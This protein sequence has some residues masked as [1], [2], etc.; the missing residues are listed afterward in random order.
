MRRWLHLSRLTVIWRSVYTCQ[1]QKV[2]GSTFMIPSRCQFPD[3]LSATL[4]P[5]FPQPNLCFLLQVQLQ[6]EPVEA[7]K[8]LSYCSHVWFLGSPA[9]NHNSTG[10]WVGKHMP[11]F[12]VIVSFAII[13]FRCSGIKCHFPMLCIS[14]RIRGN[15]DGT[16]SVPR[17]K[18]CQ[19]P[20][21]RGTSRHFQNA[22]PSRLHLPLQINCQLP[23]SFAKYGE[24]TACKMLVT[25]Q[26]VQ[27]FTSANKKNVDSVQ[28]N[29]W[30]E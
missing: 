3:F 17:T 1:G 25:L 27:K 22:S 21:G 26:S 8:Q 23:A 30:K 9:W 18:H 20:G 2:S 10:W 19:L 7:S 12:K 11:D 5:A 6:Y 4:H 15:C 14:C 13:T 28:I 16:C 29:L 24:S